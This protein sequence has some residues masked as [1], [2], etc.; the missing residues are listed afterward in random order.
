MTSIDDL[1]FA[2]TW[3]ECYEVGEDDERNAKAKES[4]IKFLEKEIAKRQKRKNA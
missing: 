4:A 1:A 3:L 2:V